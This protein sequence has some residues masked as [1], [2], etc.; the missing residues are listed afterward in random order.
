MCIF[1]A[2]EIISCC[3]TCGSDS[4][5]SGSLK[6]SSAPNLR[7][8]VSSSLLKGFELKQKS[9]LNT[10]NVSLS[11]NLTESIR[12][13]KIPQ[14]ISDILLCVPWVAV[15]YSSTSGVHSLDDEMVQNHLLLRP[16]NDVLLHCSLGDQ[17][18]NIHLWRQRAEVNILARLQSSVAG[19]GILFESRVTCF[20]WPILWALAWAC[21]SFWGFQSESKIT[22]VSAEAK[23]IPKPP[24]LVDSRKQ[25]S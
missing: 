1:D 4:S 23:L 14:L 22:T 24:A 10:E 7:M 3:D 11:K 12:E 18:I 17:S 8:A 19:E 13:K 6:S 16:L 21:R 15:Q 20:F 2:Q 25:K 5:P 9:A